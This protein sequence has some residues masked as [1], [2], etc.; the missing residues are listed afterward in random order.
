MENL[1][2]SV[3]LGLVV[4]NVDLLKIFLPPFVSFI[5]GILSV[6]PILRMMKRFDLRK[7]KNVAKS[8]D[9]RPATYAAKIDNDEGKVL[10]RMGALVAFVGMF[11]AL[12]FFRVLPIIFDSDWLAQLNFLSR[13]QTWMPIGALTIGAVIGALDD[14]IV[15]GRFRRFS[16]YVGDGLSL[17][18]R[19]GLALI[20]AVL[21][22]W[23]LT[24]KMDVTSVY[25]PFA[26][27]FNVGWI[28]VGVV[29]IAAIV[30]TYAG[31]VIDGVDGLSGGVF[32]I[33]YATFGVIAF[34]QDRYDL[35]ALCFAIVGGLLAFLW[36]NVPPAKF[37][38][39]DVGSMPL[40]IVLA[41]VSLLTDSVLVLPIISAPLVW[42][43]GSVV[44]Q[45]ISKK[46]RNGKKVFHASPFHLHLQVIG[47]EKHTVSMRYWIITALC[48][49]LGL[50]IFI[51]GGYFK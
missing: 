37:M 22:A 17:T 24:K 6:K 40:T 1:Q 16:K 44:V 30:V 43:I 27:V 11:G 39:S 48:S 46:L 36:F 45:L 47:W 18:V 26:G 4:K 19:L 35:A 13:S 49:T 28:V 7:K 41:I 34:L 3:N 10:Y 14:L 32:A 51:A 31:S 20:L 12:I 21:F 50:A 42:S 33:M 8:I 9:G 2:D 15:C 25:V 29:A 38:L 5:V 23:W